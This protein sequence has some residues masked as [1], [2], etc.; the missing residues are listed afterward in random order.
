MELREMSVRSRWVRV[1]AVVLADGGRCVVMPAEERTAVFAARQDVRH[2]IA[3]GVGHVGVLVGLVVL[4]L[5]R[6]GGGWWAAVFLATVG[7]ARVCRDWRTSVR[8]RRELA[9][10]RTCRQAAIAEAGALNVW[11]RCARTGHL[12]VQAEAG[13]R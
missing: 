4:A 5:A 10:C 2:G 9:E 7:A 3:L 6:G 11:A 13:A 8:V 1:A 12:P